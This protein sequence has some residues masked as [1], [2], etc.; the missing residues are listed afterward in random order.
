MCT[1][2]DRLETSVAFELLT[3]IVCAAG[4]ICASCCEAQISI[5]D[6]AAAEAPMQPGLLSMC[7]GDFLEV[8]LICK[9]LCLNSARSLLTMPL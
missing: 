7:A 5:P 3:T 6:L 4:S 2:L 8:R 1:M 9:C